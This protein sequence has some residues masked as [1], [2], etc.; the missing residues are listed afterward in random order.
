L[1]P[2]RS[3][4][5]PLILIILNIELVIDA[6][7]K[8]EV[9]IAVLHDK[10]LTELHREKGNSSYS[11][12]D[13]YLGKV[14]KVVPGLNAAFVNVGYEK[15]A[16]LHY[17]D[18]GPQFNSLAKFTKLALGKKLNNAYLEG[19]TLEKDIEKDG[20]MAAVLSANQNILVQIAK[21][22]ISAKGPRLS[23]EITLAGRYIVL[24][25]FSNKVSVSQKIKEDDEKKRLKE[26]IQSIRPKNFGVIIRTVAEG[27]KVSEIEGDMKDLLSKWELTFAELKNSVPPKKLLGEIDRTSA[28]LRDLLNANFHNIHVNDAKIAEEVKTYIKNIAPGRES[29]VKFYNGKVDIFEQ[30]GIQKQ[31]KAM[32]G[33]QVALPSGGYL[34]IEHTEAMHVVDV[35]SGNRKG[36]NQE[37]NA[38][39]TNM[40][41]AEELGRILRLRDMGGIVCVD[42][43]DMGDKENNKKLFEHLKE[44][45]K[46][47]RAKHNVLPP[48]KFGVVEITRQRVRPETNINTSEKCPTCDGS[49][50]IQASILI[51]DE[52][53]NHLRYVSEDLKLKK[54]LLH[55]H[56]FIAAYLTQGIFSQRYKWG[57]KYGMKIKVA[58]ENSYHMMEYSI[59]KANGELVEL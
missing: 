41:A 38:L 51:I 35:N 9:A 46:S 17:L 31:I 57:K 18:L 6:T 48:S 36:P 1:Y 55:T 10:K 34:I 4:D 29:I 30:F 58:A 12:G 47:D 20:K 50:E 13:L 19:F 15:D 54:I 40:E 21:E 11:V 2:N 39:Q 42:F 52:I 16:F 26:L 45:M 28:I 25:P 24:V 23:S 22:P 5:V 43:I 3:K 7:N 53:Q 44:I 33:K 59:N 49:G 37:Q 32:F 56:P 8:G 27:K 14:H